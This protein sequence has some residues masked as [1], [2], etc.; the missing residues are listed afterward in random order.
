M[1]ER[2][3]LHGLPGCERLTYADYGDPCGRPLLFCHGWPS[4]R[5]QARGL[6]AA[7]V[8]AG[9][10]VVAPDRP[11][12]GGSAFQPGRRL[13]D[14]P[15]LMSALADH[16]GWDRF[17]VM[18]VSG[19]GPYALACGA[20]LPERMRHL[21]LVCPA[22]PLAWSQET[23]GL[24]WAYRGLMFFRRRMAWTLAA[25]L[26][27]ARW[28]SWWPPRH[29]LLKALHLGLPESDRRA[30]D[31]PELRSVISD[32]FAEV[33][34]SSNAALVTDGEIYLEPW[35]FEPAEVLTPATIWHG[36][37]DANLPAAMVRRMAAELPHGELRRAEGEGHYSIL[38]N[39][40]AE[41]LGRVASTDSGN[42][43]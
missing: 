30:L 21:W 11:G 4:S 25:P 15:P 9:I 38:F 1:N 19:G 27:L 20:R 3:E 40:T 42:G 31:T 17:D 35:G 37:E 32:D 16:L 36:T 6:H 28:I 41:V 22:P 33:M 12:I 14:W 2:V 23:G 13:L 5:L 34:R 43:H 18:G 29:P 39:L 24:H 8:A 7:A 26:G 10:R